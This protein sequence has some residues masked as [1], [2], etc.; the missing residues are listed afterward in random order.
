GTIKLNKADVARTVEQGTTTV[1]VEGGIAAAKG[2]LHLAV[3][4]YRQALGNAPAGS[5]AA[6]RLQGKITKITSES[7]QA[8][9]SGIINDFN[10]A[11]VLITN[12]QY[13]SAQELLERI[14][15]MVAPDDPLTSRIRQLQ[16]SI[17][18]GDRKSTRL[19]SSHVKISYAV[20]CLKKK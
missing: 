10:N 14:A 2:D 17:Y 11:Q 6:E 4:R 7:R 3:T 1:E 9:V 12:R 16:A 5:L 15:P 8:T 18:Y 13:E 20:F 19:N